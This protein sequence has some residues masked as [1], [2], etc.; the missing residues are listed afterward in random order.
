ME[1]RKNSWFHLCRPIHKLWTK[2]SANKVNLSMNGLLRKSK[3]YR[4]LRNLMRAIWWI[5]RDL[6]L[7]DNAALGAALEA[8]SVIPTF[9]LD[10]V[11]S[12][13]S[14]RRKDFLYAG[15]QT[16]AQDLRARGSYLV[17]RSGKPF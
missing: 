12:H 3:N 5:R 7:T 15:L 4:H 1:R 6:R 9:I 13:S 11:F 8:G 2:S 14:P 16:L 17:I 10:P